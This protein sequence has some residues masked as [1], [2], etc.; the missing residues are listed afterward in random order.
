[1]RGMTKKKLKKWSLKDSTELYQISKWGEGYFG[2]NAEGDL[3]VIPQKNIEGPKINIR[4]V[5]EEAKKENLGFPLVMRFHDILRDRIRDLNQSFLNII[6]EAEYKGD[7]YGVYPI[8]VNQLR[9]VVEEIVEAGSD[10]NY[11]LEA[12]SKP[13][14]M[15]VLA[16]NTNPTALTILNGY[17]DYQ[18]MKLA[19][20]GTKL[21]RKMIIVIEKFSELQQV[22]EISEDLDVEPMIG[23]RAKLSSKASGKWAESSGDFAKFGLSIPQIVQMVEVLKKHNKLHMLKLFH[24]HVGSQIPDIR[25]LKECLIEGAHIFVHLKKLGAPIEYFDA[26]GGVGISYDGSLSSEGSSTNYTLKEYIADVVYN[27]KEICDINNVDH[28]NI[29]TET[30]RAMAAHHSFVVTNVFGEIS[31][32]AQ[33]NLDIAENPKDHRILKNMKA[34]LRDLDFGNY[35]DTYHDA[36]L[37]KAESTSAFKLGVLDLL[38]RSQIEN[39]YWAI[40]QKIINLTLNTDNVPDVVKSLKKELAS[41][42]LCNFSLFQSLPDSWA[43][44]QVFPIVPI[45]HHN[46]KPDIHCTLADITCDS[47]G[48]VTHFIG[49]DQDESSLLLHSRPLNQD[50]YLGIFL[51]GAYQDVMGDMHNLFGRLNEVHVY[52][53]DEDPNDFYIE[54]IIRGHSAGEVLEIM[55]YDKTEMNRL[56]KQQVDKKIKSGDIK[57]RIGVKLTDFYE[58]SLNS[59][60]YLDS[61]R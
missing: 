5:I 58:E 4:E 7:Y 39:I 8:K 47:D 41:K 29:V 52:C 30:G 56:I 23:V 36:S 11:G 38:E 2:L 15:A 19:M 44:D 46:Q 59:Y 33:D 49:K 26:G 14:L 55:Q 37:F 28:P 18:Y 20:L 60:T 27:L 35:Y 32:Q 42:Y 22:L 53:D 45:S 13:E 17:K 21:G 61:K 3:C 16:Y 24:F 48:K 6:K 1:M 54:E 34:L 57:P 50:Y 51:T 10:Y 12:G 25:T 31:L 9:E 43:I 40:C